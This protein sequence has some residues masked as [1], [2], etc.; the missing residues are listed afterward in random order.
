MLIRVLD[1]ALA[2]ECNMAAIVRPYKN[3]RKCADGHP[4]GHQK[5]GFVDTTMDTK[6][7]FFGTP[8]WTLSR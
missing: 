5:L 4:G 7:R 2:P 3:S 6:T 8:G 1:P